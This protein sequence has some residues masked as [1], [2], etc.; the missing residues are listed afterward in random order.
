[1]A[2]ISLLIVCVVL[3]FVISMLIGPMLIPMLKAMHFGQQI[4]EI[5]PKWHEGK[6]GTPTMGG[7]IFITGVTFV[8]I[9]FVNTLKGVFLLVFTLLCGAIGF[10][11]DYVKIV[12]KRNMGL[13]PMGKIIL[14]LIVT[15]LFCIL[16]IEFG[17]IKTT[18]H[19]PFT[20]INLEMGYFISLFYIF[21]MIGF[22]NSVNLTDGVDGLAGTVTAVAMFFFLLMSV[23][24][25]N[26]DLAIFSASLCGGLC[27]FLVFNFHPAKVFMGDTGSLYLGG[28]VVAASI[29]LD[30]PLILVIVGIVYLIEAVSVMLQVGFF[31]LTHGKRLFKM[32]PF[33]HHLEM[34]GYSENKIVILFGSI[35]FLG[36]II[37]F[38]SML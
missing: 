24:T 19:I 5:G 15:T 27:G 7:F 28:A 10:M 33:H 17:I 30:D 9:M 2:P 21:F 6:N 34:C 22:I 16:G 18:L 35:T 13:S 14:M 3:T 1:M 11:D 29:F 20:D 36:G 4:L 25:A 38:L 31:K 23:L 8:G 12:R 26:D 37:A 32:A